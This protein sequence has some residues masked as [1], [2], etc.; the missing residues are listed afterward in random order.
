[1]A[2]ASVFREI[3]SLWPSV[4]E[5]KR[6]DAFWERAQGHL[7]SWSTL[8]RCQTLRCLPKQR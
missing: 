2:L 8:K 1:M 3:I 6:S 5:G 7:L 4:N